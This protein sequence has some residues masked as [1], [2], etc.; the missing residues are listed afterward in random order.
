[1]SQFNSG[2]RYLILLERVLPNYER[3]QRDLKFEVAPRDRLGMKRG[4]VCVSKSVGGSE[5]VY[6]RNDVD[7]TVREKSW[8]VEFHW[9]VVIFRSRFSFNFLTRYLIEETSTARLNVCRLIVCEQ[10]RDAI[11]K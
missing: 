4:E 6:T 10:V 3:K 2:S 5:C 1:M 11:A 9:R 8:S 7:R